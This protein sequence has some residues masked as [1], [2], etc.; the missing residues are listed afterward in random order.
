MAGKPM[1]ISRDRAK[2]YNVTKVEDSSGKKRRVIDNGDEVAQMM[3]ACDTD[4]KLI[5]LAKEHGL[6]ER[7]KGWVHLNRGQQRMNLGN[8]LRA[9]LRKDRAPPKP[10]KEPA[11]AKAPAEKKAAA[12]KGSNKKAA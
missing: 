3:R 4:D 11:A 9:K 1:S 10:E 2:E 5:A 8:S 7:W 12:G 6:Y